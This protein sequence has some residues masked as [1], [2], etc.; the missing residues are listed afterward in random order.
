MCRVANRNV[1][2]L[3]GPLQLLQSWIFWRFPILR[4]RGFDT[5]SFLLASRWATYLPLSD[6]K[7]ERV[8]Q[9][10]LALDRLG[11]RDIVWEPYASLDVM[12]VVHP[13]ILTEENSRLWRACTCLIYFV[14]IEWHQV[15]R[16]MPQL[17]GVQHEPEP[18]LNIN[19]PHAKDG[20]GGDRWFPSYYQVWHP[21]WQNRFDAVLSIPQVPDPGPFVDFLQW[22]YSVAFRFLSSDSLIADPRA[23]EISQDVIQRGSSHA[24]SRVPMPDVLDNRRVERRRC[25]GTRATDREWRWLD[26]MI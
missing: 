26:D 4:P 20:R 16:V 13:Y 19:W 2:N 22:W 15:D 8:I 12:A 5:Y 14:V 11:D 9:C 3:A 17:G 24:P 25:V 23:E 1:T 6:H 7:E 21:S 18:A 10:R